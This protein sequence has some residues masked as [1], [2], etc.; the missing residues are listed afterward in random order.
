MV[1][2]ISASWSQPIELQDASSE[3][4]IY[5]CDLSTTP[6][7]PGIYVFA[8]V[9]GDSISPLYVGQAA[10]VKSRLEQQFNNVRLMMG[11]S[12]ATTGKRILLVAEVHLKPGQQ[13]D[14]VLDVFEST[15]I[16]HP[17]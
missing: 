17:L 3:N 7:A 12:R 5:S 4:L 2:K 13:R 8:R 6:S 14:K 9:H 10:N 11:I 16:G 15:L 1:L